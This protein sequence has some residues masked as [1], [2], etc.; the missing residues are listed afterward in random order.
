VYNRNGLGFKTGM[1]I[2][3]CAVRTGSLNK[4]LDASS[5]YGHCYV[6]VSKY[7]LLNLCVIRCVFTVVSHCVYSKC[8]NDAYFY[9]CF[10]YL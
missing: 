6:I 8:D 9:V 5:W 4:T 2:V 3:Y 7:L 10:K 1:N